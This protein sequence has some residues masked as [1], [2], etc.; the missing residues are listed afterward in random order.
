MP[1]LY[2]IHFASEQYPVPLMKAFLSIF[3]RLQA[4]SCKDV[5]NLNRNV[6][7]LWKSLNQLQTDISTLAQALNVSKDQLSHKDGQIGDL[8]SHN[9][10]LTAQ[11]ANTNMLLNKSQVIWHINNLTNKHSSTNQCSLDE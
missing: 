9:S 10:N 2:R 1:S 5:D 11:L 4:C 3:I 6:D 8:L 7:S